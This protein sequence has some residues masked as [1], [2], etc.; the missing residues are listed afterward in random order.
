MSISSRSFR[1]EKGAIVIKARNSPPKRINFQYNPHTI[2][3]SLNPVYSDRDGETFLTYGAPPSEKITVTIEFD[4]TDQLEGVWQ[5]FGTKWS[6]IRPQ[7]AALETILYPPSDQGSDKASIVAEGTLKIPL[8]TEMVT[9][10]E[11]GKKRAIPV[12]ITGYT[13]DEEEYDIELNPIRA[14]IGITMDVLTYTESKLSETATAIYQAY[15]ANKE[16]EA[17]E[18]PP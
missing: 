4:A 15:H 17:K 11:F 16:A 1:S 12:K 2:K 9:V 6:G 10:F 3:R 13:I 14:T 7:L 18:L 8:D 5:N